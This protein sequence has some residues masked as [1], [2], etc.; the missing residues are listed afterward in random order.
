MTALDT[1]I[2]IAITRLKA[3][4]PRRTRKRKQDKLANR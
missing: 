4:V 2:G 3:F 1:K